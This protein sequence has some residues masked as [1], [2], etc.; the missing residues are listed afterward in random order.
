MTIGSALS[1]AVSAINAQSQALSIISNNLANASTVGYKS[2][3]TSFSDLIA[4][5]A[6]A[7]E[8]ASGGVTAAAAQNV[9]AQ[10]NISSASQSTDIAIDGSGFFAV[11]YNKD[12]T[13]TYF[14]RDGEF[15][16][17]KNGYLVNNGY[18]LMGWPTDSSGNITSTDTNSISG[19]QA[20]NINKYSTSAAASTTATLKANLPADAATSKTFTSSMTIYDSLGVAQSVPITYEKTASNT[21]TM[22]LGDPTDP[23]DSTSTTGAIG[24]NTTYTVN[25]NSDGTL[26]S[27]TDSSGATVTDVTITVSSWTDGAASSSVAMNVG[28]ADEADGLTQYASGSDDPQVEI[29]STDRNGVAYGHLTGVT[30]SADGT[31]T[32]AYDN[33]QSLPIYK[34]AVATFPNTNGLEVKS[35]NVYQ[36]TSD[37]G[38]YTLHAAGEGGAGKIDGASLEASNVSTADQL[39]LMIV[40]Q[41][42]YSAAS[43]VIST[44]KTMFDDLISAIR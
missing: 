5:S 20:I 12:I 32:A 17:D 2:V 44:C 3:T 16:T 28:T 4:G 10:G 19:L 9:N 34:I 25:F 15:D 21:W 24:G 41:Q 11:T 42:N 38:T 33:G 30:I 26:G 43:Q 1:S 22:T 23:S 39:S 13:Q 18:Y 35:D 8:L 37:S 27:I 36:M 7:K 29:S 40:A 14:T 31:I 6:S